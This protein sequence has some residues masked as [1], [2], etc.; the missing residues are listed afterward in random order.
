MTTVGATYG[1][2]NR[3]CGACSGWEMVSVRLRA[4]VVADLIPNI[5]SAHLLAVRD[6]SCGGTGAKGSLIGM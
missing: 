4:S 6:A 3:G 2:G 1:G 5:A